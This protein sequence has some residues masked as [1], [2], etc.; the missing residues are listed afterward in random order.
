LYLVSGNLY[1]YSPIFSERK[2]NGKI[3]S[4]NIIP[5]DKEQ[6]I[7]LKK[8]EKSEKI[9][10]LGYKTSPFCIFFYSTLHLYL[11]FSFSYYEFNLPSIIKRIFENSFLV[12]VYVMFS[13]IVIDKVLPPALELLIDIFSKL[14]FKVEHKTIRIA[15]DL[16]KLPI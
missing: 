7:E 4:S 3:L 6:K 5:P 10:F 14:S 12:L 8:D 9:N 2:R 13:L 1:S 15:D 11:Y 16:I